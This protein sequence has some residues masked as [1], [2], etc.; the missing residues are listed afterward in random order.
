MGRAGLLGLAAGLGVNLPGC[1]N[2]WDDVTSRDFHFRSIWERSEPA[3]VLET[4]TDGDQRAKAMRALKEPRTNGGTTVEQ[5]RVM[6]WLNQSAV[7]DS[8]PV[9]RL[10]AIQTLGRFT[11]P[12]C[13]QI[14]IAAFDAAPQLQPDVAVAVQSSALTALG[15]TRQQT[16][17]AFLIRAASKPTPTE[18]V[19]REINQA[20]DV[21]LAAVRA[22]KNFEASAEVAA[23]MAQMLRSERDVAVLDRA[24]ETYVKVAGREPPDSITSPIAP[25]PLPGR[26][27]DIKLTGGTPADSK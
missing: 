5:D 7:G 3:T 8:Q 21:R 20:R 23:A 27:D 6:Q 9:C 18:V 14:L 26:S 25:V 1:A 11:D 4:S 2:T 17:I 12:R 15:E 13:V 24:R 10:A 16:A 22:L 19:D